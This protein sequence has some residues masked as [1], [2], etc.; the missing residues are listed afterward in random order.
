MAMPFPAQPPHSLLLAWSDG[1]L[2][3]LSAGLLLGK[4]ESAYGDFHWTS[5]HR[6][7]KISFVVR[8]S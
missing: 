8:N 7:A 5:Q 3:L 1:R 6:E 2:A 4:Q